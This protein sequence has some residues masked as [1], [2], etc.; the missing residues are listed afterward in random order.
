MPTD[1]VA[2]SSS[3]IPG[4]SESVDVARMLSGQAQDSMIRAA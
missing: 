4:S 1:P 2:R 3:T